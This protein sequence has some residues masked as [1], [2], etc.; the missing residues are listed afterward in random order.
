MSKTKFIICLLLVTLIFNAC[1]REEIIYHSKELGIFKFDMDDSL[2]TKI[3]TSR[4][5]RYDLEPTPT[6]RYDKIGYNLDKL[7][8]RGQTAT[9]YPRKSYAVNMDKEIAFS[10]N[11]NTFYEKF[12]LVS[13][14]ADYTYIENRL[15][16]L[17]L[18]QFDL[19]P[20][21]TFYTQVQINEEH[22]GLYMFIEDPEDYLLINKNAEG[23]IRRYY[24]N[25]ITELEISKES[26]FDS[27]KIAS[28]F[29]SIYQAITLYQG[30]EL[31]DQ[32]ERKMD[33]QH[34]M[35]KLAI[36]MLLMNGDYTDEILFYATLKEGKMYFDVLP[37]D[38]DDIFANSPHEVGNN[39]S[40]GK[41]FGNRY[42]DNYD[43]WKQLFGN[44]LMFSVEDDLD[45]IIATDNVLHKTYLNELEY[46]FSTL[47]EQKISE[48]F[49][50]LQSELD[51]FYTIPEIITLSK[52]DADESS[53]EKYT[54]NIKEKEKL[55][56][57]RYRWIKQEIQNQLHQ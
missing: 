12:K 43:N 40:V 29:K 27:V 56:K 24:R 1:Y 9:N 14:V 30:K 55:L 39:W 53:V 28:E 38:Y 37:W 11:P 47:S 13:M 54:Q 42:Y 3:Q 52:L 31:K 15:S 19:W 44:K 10:D 36:D 35:Q 45:Y 21:K 57:E 23:V 8:V 2:F 7:R 22:Q 17:L 51:P 18:S 20:L 25:G 33:L 26:T 5:I 46:V 32:L 16:Q 41:L 34:Y 48:I 6:L 4:G 49:R 50:Q